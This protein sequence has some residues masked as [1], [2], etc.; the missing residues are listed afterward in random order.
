MPDFPDRSICLTLIPQEAADPAK[1]SGKTPDSMH[2]IRVGK[3]KSNQ[4]E[5]KSD[6]DFA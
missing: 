3:N 4:Q 5:P 2:F 6:R 1:G